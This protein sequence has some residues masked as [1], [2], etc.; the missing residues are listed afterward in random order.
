MPC[1]MKRPLII[2]V[3]IFSLMIQ[4]RY[5][6]LSP[7]LADSQLYPFS[8]L[9]CRLTNTALTDVLSHGAFFPSIPSLLHTPL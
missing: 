5:H 4:I 9:A 1:L 8:Y 3:D 2:H 7:P 6:Q